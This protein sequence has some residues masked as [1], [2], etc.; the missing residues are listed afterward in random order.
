[1]KKIL[2]LLVTICNFWGMYGQKVYELFSPNKTI[3]VEITISDGIYYNIFC[4][5][6]LLLEHGTLQMKMDDNIL[7]LHPKVTGNKTRTVNESWNPVVPFKFSTIVNHYNQ[8][9]LNFR[10]NYSV[11]FRAFDDGVAYRFITNKK[12][13]VEIS[14]ELFQVNLPEGYLLHIQQSNGFKTAYE[15]SYRHLRS[16]EWN[17][18]ADKYTLLPVLVEAKDNYKILISE[19]DLTDYPAMFLTAKGGKDKLTSVFPRNPIEFGEEGDRSVKLLKEAEYLA[20]TQGK[21]NF[22][23]RYFVITSE[24]GQL[25]ENTMTARLAEPCKIADPSWI[26]PGL[27]TWEWWNGAIPYGP[28]V[29]FVA[30]CNT[31]TYKYFIDFASKFGLEYILLDEGWAQSTR[32]PYTPNENLDLQ[33]LIQYGK[34]KNVGVVLWLTWLTVENNFELFK[35]FAEWGIKGVKVDFMDRSDQWMVNFYE[36]VAAEAAKYKLFV[37]FHGAFKPAGLEY[38]YPNV[39]SYEGVRAMEQM[40]GCIPDNSIFLPFLRNAVGPMDY[41]PGAMLCYQPETYRAERPNSGSIG[42]RAY[43]MALFILFETGL[44]MMA[45]NPTL[46]YREEDCTLFM[47]EIPVETDETVALAAKVGEYVVVAKRKNNKWYIGGITNGDKNERVLDLSLDFLDANRD[48]R[49]TSYEDGVNAN[50]QAMHYVKKER[51]VKKGQT[52]QIKMARNGGFA[53]VIE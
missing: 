4:Q 17:Q 14:D 30:G 47:A 43:Q 53:A 2:I 18:S 31:D 34:Q 44:Q 9:L 40:G 5:N 36:R 50:R 51:Q 52:L 8:L 23:W 7:G 35:T 45:D 26:K 11:E 28:D 39:L 22:P 3:R 12:G 46:Y 49:I 27:T 32:N 38:K 16:D 6:H 1:M 15:E 21:R 19:S 37:D 13:E 20:K 29:D 42:T 33:E 24:D 25:I 41:T 48:Y 10:G